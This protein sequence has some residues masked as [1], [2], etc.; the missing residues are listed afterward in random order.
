[1][2]LTTP[3]PTGTRSAARSV[4]A[5]AFGIT[6]L[7]SAGGSLL[8]LLRD[9]L[10]ARYF[11]ADQGTD[12][13]LV[14]WTVPETAAPLLIEDAMAFLMVPAFS[15][16]IA[17]EKAGQEGDGAHGADTGGAVSI[18]QPAGRHRAGGPA[19]PPSGVIAPPRSAEPDVRTGPRPLPAPVADLVAAT[20]P[21]L[22]GLLALVSAATLFG[23][24]L[25]VHL[26]A[27]GLADPSLA[28][29]CTRL[30]ALTILPFGLTGYLSAGL[31]AHHR[32]T[33][34]GS[35]Y[36]AYNTGI[37]A[38]MVLLHGSL[39]VRAAAGG[40][41]L[42][43]V[44]MTAVLLPLFSRHCARLT[45]R[46][47]RAG[48]A[49]RAVPTLAV[50]PWA[51]LP[52]ALF[53]LTRQSQVFI[54]RFLA[55]EL[56]PGTISH[57]NYAEKVAQMAMTLGVMVCTVTFP[58]VARA[59]AEGDLAA[60]RARVEKDLVLVGALV[61]AGTSVLLACAPQVVALLFQRGEFT[62][63][64]T[65][66]T[67]SVMRVYSLGLLGQA[68][69][70]TLVRPFFST[71]PAVAFS[72]GS[73]GAARRRDGS[74][75]FPLLAMAVGLLVT[76][77]LGVSTVHWFG[78]LGLAAANATGI[79]L[80]AVLLLVGIRTRGVAVRLH[81]V[82]AGQARLLLAAAVSTAAA[83]L[84]TLPVDGRPLLAVLLGGVVGPVAFVLAAAALREPTVTGPLAALV[85]RSRTRGRQD[86][87]DGQDEGE[88]QRG[89]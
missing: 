19:V 89:R 84:A 59:L 34:P 22:A 83:Y 5:R 33:G 10:L 48:T 62:A 78:A 15:L 56:T 43:S 75:W 52:I 72:S 45:P 4:L 73:S 58:V 86:G 46:R 36:I 25:L 57:L 54:E 88:S 50:S 29:V 67:A 17:A 64:D 11:G 23:A 47:S 44:L 85:A 61:L 41:A 2:T 60:A 51:L 80:T 40:V 39:G 63:A 69:V 70:G 76:G 68:M 13:F 37:L 49:G 1:M 77:V 7:L 87:P 12:A 71:R 31:R 3:R 42:G 35:V 74:D 66:A 18:P 14:A 30:T 53:T 81:V 82:L 28:V 24:P 20:L 27:P 21:P 8:G 16:A 6:A 55:S 9:L 26:L 38:V 79:T 32:F 65:A